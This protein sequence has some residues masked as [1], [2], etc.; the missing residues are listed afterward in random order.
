MPHHQVLINYLQHQPSG[1][2]RALTCPVSS[3]LMSYSTNVSVTSSLMQPHHC[4]RQCPAPIQLIQLS[5][6]TVP[7]PTL[8]HSLC[9]HQTLFRPALPYSPPSVSLIDLIQHCHRNPSSSSSLPLPHS[10]T[11]IF[12][13]APSINLSCPA[14]PPCSHPA[15][16]A[17]VPPSPH[18]ALSCP[19][20]PSGTHPTLTYPVSSIRIS[21]HVLQHQSVVN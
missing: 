2:Q 1:P 14:A 8:S 13:T 19:A 20:A 4:V 11:T 15:H 18:R 21:P 17:A 3:L 5:S 7:L 10:R 9:P 16:P 6:T 12:P